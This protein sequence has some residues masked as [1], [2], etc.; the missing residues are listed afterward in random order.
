MMAMDSTAQDRILNRLSSGGEK[1][2]A[3]FEEIRPEIWPLEVYSD[4]ASWTVLEILKHLV[5]A[6]TSIRRLVEDILK[7]GDGVP[8]GFDLDRYNES[9]V[10]KIGERSPTDLLEEFSTARA[11]TVSLVTKM[12]PADFQQEGRHPFL[13][14]ASV[15][16]I[17][18]LM[19]THTQIHQ[20]DIRRQIKGL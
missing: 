12:S 19:Y 1:T 5:D 13:G 15:E 10:R 16:D 3:F 7:G 4:G 17:L 20:R 14:I 6:E 8:E 18:K 9:K 11:A 2:L